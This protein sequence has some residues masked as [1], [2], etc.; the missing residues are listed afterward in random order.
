MIALGQTLDGP[1]TVDLAVTPH[2]LIG[3]STG[4][5]KTYLVKSVIA[6]ALAKDYE[7][8][9][10]DLKGGV[11]FP[12]SWQGDRCS[13]ADNRESA[14]SMLS[15]LTRT[16][17]SRKSTF[18]DRENPCASLGEYNRRYPDE[19]MP[20]I[21]VACDEIAELT[22]TTGLDKPNKELVTAIVGQLSTLA[23]LGRAFGIH[24]VLA[25]Q[26]PDAN[27]LP[28]QIKNNID[29]RICGRADLVLSQI[30]L[31][32]GDAAALPKDIPGRFLCNLDSGTL[33]QGYAI[34]NALS[35]K[36]GGLP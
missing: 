11:D 23:R 33:F 13:Y 8:C 15:Y 6:Q 14:L 27:V 4:S 1:L 24:L 12:R 3:G 17:A 30:I 26:R 9:L 7:V 21:M 20:R 10:I 31:D 22:D 2:M 28:G 34:E 35:Q 5:G 25:T 18:Q 19:A 36:G 16:L 32:N 29:I